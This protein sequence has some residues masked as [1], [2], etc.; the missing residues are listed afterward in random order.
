VIA[1][2][3]SSCKERVFCE[4]CDEGFR[5]SNSRCQQCPANCQEY[6]GLTTCKVCE[7][8]HFLLNSLCTERST[9]LSKVSQALSDAVSSLGG[10]LSIGSSLFP[11]TKLVSK[12][13]QNTRY[14]D[15]IVTNE[16]TEV[17]QNWNTNLINVDIPDAFS[18]SAMKSKP[19]PYV[20][21]RYDLNAKFLINFWSNL[22][23]LVGILGI[24]IVGRTLKGVL[25]RRQKASH[26]WR[27][28]L[29]ER[30]V[31]GSLNLTLVQ[32]YGCLDD[33]IF[34][35]ALDAQTNT[36]KGGFFWVSFLIGLAFLGLAAW[37]ILFNIVVVKR[38]Q[39]AKNSK[40]DLKGFRQNNKHWE[41]FYGDFNDVDSWSHSFLALLA[42]RNCFSSFLITVLYSSPL[43][44]TSLL[45]VIDGA[46]IIFLVVKKPLAGLRDKLSQYFFQVIALLVHICTFGLG[47]QGDQ[48][49]IS[50]LL[51]IILCK[52]I[53]YLNYT[54]TIGG[55]GFMLLEIY[56]TISLKV[57]ILRT[58]LKKKPEDNAVRRFEE[59]EDS[60]NQSALSTGKPFDLSSAALNTEADKKGNSINSR[61][62]W[63]SKDSNLCFEQTLNIEVN[64]EEGV[65]NGIKS[66]LN[67]DMDHHHEHENSTQ[68]GSLDK[69]S[70][71]FYK[72]KR[73]LSKNLE[74]REMKTDGG[75]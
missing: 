1:D 31:A 72:P 51:K 55:V 15:L 28:S 3:S 21:A 11:V 4:S 75:Q 20:F 47:I 64:I 74:N 48:I 50:N 54:L 10:A 30:I 25:N 61:K 34:Y 38:Y 7:K 44:Q 37:L 9:S 69:K 6:S 24:F 29:L 33:V 65:P 13:V 57:K 56:A 19:L 66:D 60:V 41:L 26:S 17:Y 23:I 70:R 27:Y 36:F 58:K 45:V 73:G 43:I 52:S 32:G 5:A 63:P 40:Q 59:G 35:F 62:V 42:I 12:I 22:V 46:I 16:L 2:S 8:G 14:L 53:I 18:S 68:V 71:R 39:R 49:G 67:Q